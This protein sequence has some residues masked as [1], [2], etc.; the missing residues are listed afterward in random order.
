MSRRLRSRNRRGMSLI[1]MMLVLGIMAILMSIGTGAYRRMQINNLFTSDVQRFGGEVR[2]LAGL[3]RAVGDISP[4]MAAV[5]N[6]NLVA[7][8][9]GG[10]QGW[11]WR[12]YENGKLRQQ[13]WIGQRETIWVQYSQAY[14][15]RNVLTK[16]VW[17]EL[18]PKT[19]SPI[20][21]VIFEP[22]GTPVD[23]GSIL[24]RSRTQNFRINITKLGSIQGP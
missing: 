16:G 8:V 19:G 18:G 1:E 4:A 11:T 23:S 17:L 7:E 15:Y 9:A 13:G 20:M 5:N 6:E 22:D 10:A 24:L 21:Q 12:T 3:A 14:A 2:N